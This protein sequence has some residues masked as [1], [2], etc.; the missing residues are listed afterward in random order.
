M[1]RITEL[2]NTFT[3]ALDSAS[4][5]RKIQ[6]L[7]QVDEQLFS[8]WKQY[9]SVY[10]EPIR[11]E[12]SVLSGIITDLVLE[13][14]HS[15]KRNRI[16]FSGCGTSGRIGW[17]CAR[18]YAKVFEA[19]ASAAAGGEG[20]GGGGGG[21][22]ERE[23]G[24]AASSQKA[25]K[26]SSSHHHQPFGY[27]CSGGDESLVVS[28]ELP[29]DDPHWGARDLEAATKG[30][31]TVVFVGITC[32]LSAAYVAGQID[33]AMKCHSTTITVL[34][35][36]NPV[37]LARGSPVEGWD[38]T[39]RAVFLDL[40]ARALAEKVKMAA[41]KEAEK[42]EEEEAKKVKYSA[43]APPAA[44]RPCPPRPI[45]H[46]RS[47]VLNP[48]PG[49]EAVTGSSRM[50]GGSLTKILLD[51]VCLPSLATATAATTATTIDTPKLSAMDAVDLNAAAYRAAYRQPAV[52]ARLVHAAR[53]ALRAPNGRLYYLGFGTLGCVGLLDA[54]EMVDTYG[55]GVDEVRAYLDDGWDGARAN[56]G[57]LAMD[58]ELYEKYG[59]AF[60]VGFTDFATKWTRAHPLSQDDTVI[61][62]HSAQE[63]PL[64][65]KP[66][67]AEILEM[68]AAS[69]AQCLG[70]S[71][72]TD[73]T[74]GHGSGGVGGV[75]GGGDGIFGAFSAAGVT[76]SVVNAPSE[77]FESVTPMILFGALTAKLICNVIT[78]LANVE[79]GCV[80]GNTM[81]NLTVSNNK[82]FHRSAGIVVELTGCSELEAKMCLMRAAHLRDKLTPSQ[83][84]LPLS[85]HI[86]AATP[87]QCVVPTA[88]LLATGSYTVDE[89]R[90]ALAS[91]TSLGGL[92]GNLKQ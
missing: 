78:T 66:Q 52:L 90:K 16:I 4:T 43:A 54:S 32:G 69:D 91:C 31:D 84:A 92:L 27:L 73:M 70:V 72:V 21:G 49:P 76:F 28:N 74:G 2:A 38:T 67:H 58:A 60:E 53:D 19:A 30:A 6:L 48:I 71:L 83:L 39:A 18:A 88:A 56:A 25:T 44:K 36:F 51:A 57:D 7:R 86:K 34:I 3:A 20:E 80:V 55:R 46:R 45:A 82:L 33:A 89:A 41:A 75:G 14:L 62:L 61:V 87:R 79:K 64:P 37:E 35:G 12:L 1:V 26:K 9:A 63:T 40:E 42:A 15:N 8:G 17:L 65:L 50:K 22:E 5:D 81:I 59:A 23:A 13:N 11:S 47:F 29:E 10:D 85:E 68:V 24:A 77:P